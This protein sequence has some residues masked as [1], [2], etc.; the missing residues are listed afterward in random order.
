[1]PQPTSDKKLVYVLNYV[2]A[3]DTQHFVHV[4]NLLT[5]LKELGWSVTV[6]SEKGGEG[7]QSILGHDVHYMSRDGG[8]SRLLRLAK[9]LIGLRRQGYRLIFVRIS[10]PAALVAAL[11]ARPFGWKTLYW[12]S[13]ATDDFNS[14]Q[15]LV[16]RSIDAAILKTIFTGIHRFVTGPESM[17]TYYQTVYRV[18]ARKCVLLYNDIDVDRY[19][20]TTPSAPARDLSILI[21]HRLSPVRETDRYMPGIVAAL[22]EY[23][24]Q[25]QRVRLNIVGDGPERPA[26]EKTAAAAAGGLE[27]VFHGAVPNRRVHE[28]Y[29][30]ADIFIMPSYREGFPRVIIEAMAMGLPI[31]TTDAGGTRDLLGPQQSKFV[32]ARDDAAAFAAKLKSLAAAPNKRRELGAENR[33]EVMRFSTSAV[34]HMYDEALSTLLAD[35]EQQRDVRVDHA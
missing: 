22:S 29:K 1:M 11:L 10:R 7:V 6:I 24:A 5:R 4:L 23:A 19:Q 17:I 16:R 32:A 26:L 25:G 33:R 30:T 15:P 2:N 31:V 12:L 27:V 9:T 20:A 21:L 8:W 3:D 28:F 14:R 13:G 34:A 35:G 18:P